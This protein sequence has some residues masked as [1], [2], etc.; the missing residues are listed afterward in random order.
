MRWV[1]YAKLSIVLMV[2]Q[3]SFLVASKSFAHEL[4]NGYL[5]LSGEDT[6]QLEGRLSLMPYD[7]EIEVKLDENFDRDLTSQ[8]VKAAH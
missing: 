8:D 6:R 1:Y 4:S 5:T 7:L 2:L 3:L